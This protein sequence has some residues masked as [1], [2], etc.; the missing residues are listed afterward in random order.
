MSGI[1]RVT[2]GIKLKGEVTP[3]PNKNSIV[4]ALPAAILSDEDVV[5]TNVPATS[6]VEK[7]LQLMKMMGAVVEESVGVVKINCKNLKSQKI[8]YF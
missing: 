6:D 2:G 3:I 4:A 1:I 8:D 5:F 7:I